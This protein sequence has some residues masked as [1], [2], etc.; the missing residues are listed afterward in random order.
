MHKRIL[1]KAQM[2]TQTQF[3][4]VGLD[5]EAVSVVLG[6]ELGGATLTAG[7]HTASETLSAIFTFHLFLFVCFEK[8]IFSWMSFC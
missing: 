7:V 3:E 5:A 2:L 6:G 4:A 1:G 8:Q